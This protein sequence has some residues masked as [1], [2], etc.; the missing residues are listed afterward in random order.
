M[1]AGLKGFLFAGRGMRRRTPRSPFKPNDNDDGLASTVRASAA[2]ESSSTVSEGVIRP[3][4]LPDTGA[5]GSTAEI[6][7][8]LE[9]AAAE[10][11]ELRRAG[12]NRNPGGFYGVSLAADGTFFAAHF[13]RTGAH[14]SLGPYH[15]AV[16]AALML[17]RATKVS[18]AAETGLHGAS[19]VPT[20][21][22]RASPRIATA[23]GFGNPHRRTPDPDGAIDPHKLPRPSSP[24]PPP[25]GLAEAAEVESAAAEVESAAAEVESAAEA[26]ESAAEAVESAA[27]AGGGNEEES[28]PPVEAP[29]PSEEAEEVES[30]AKPEG[31]E[32]ENEVVSD[33]EEEEEL[34][35]SQPEGVG[36]A[37]GTVEGVGA[38]EEEAAVE[39]QGSALLRHTPPRASA[40]RARDSPFF[41]AEA[42]SSRALEEEARNKAAQS[43]GA[44]KRPADDKVPAHSPAHSPSTRLPTRTAHS[45]SQ[46]PSH[47]PAHSPAE[48]AH[49]HTHTRT[50]THT[51]THTHTRTHTCSSTSCSTALSWRCC[52]PS[53]CR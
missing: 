53:A 24:P 26:V 52:T 49:T 40:L 7:D 37:A 47:S 21:P 30:A 34:A 35:D 32:D 8:Y 5:G 2:T 11:L 18:V 45:P 13:D 28:V 17:A 1:R 43:T 29:P 46:S 16:E 20:P 39:T 36:A 3:R 51:H 25:P 50:H 22:C 48:H 41:R 38:V 23:L 44:R 27:E 31:G 42:L 12:S 14:A 4:L 19:S 33:T 15:S 6:T 9:L 10:G